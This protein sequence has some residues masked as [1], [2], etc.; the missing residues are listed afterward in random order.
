MVVVPW[1]AQ[2]GEVQAVDQAPDEAP[3]VQ[4]STRTSNKCSSRESTN[5]NKPTC[6]AD[7]IQE[8]L[9]T[10]VQEEEEDNNSPAEHPPRGTACTTTRLS[11]AVGIRDR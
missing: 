1:A 3:E 11:Q 9:H 2:E 10:A 8:V 6:T 5:N 4:V 7:G